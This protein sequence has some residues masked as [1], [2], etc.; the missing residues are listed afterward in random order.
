VWTLLASCLAYS[1]VLKMEAVRSYET[2][3]DFYQTERRCNQ[4]STILVCLLKPQVHQNICPRCDAVHL[5]IPE[6]RSHT[7]RD[8]C[9]FQE[10]NC[11][12]FSALE[13]YSNVS[14]TT[15]LTR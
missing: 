8:L 13:T 4:V 15:D 7:K 14:A 9:S 5:R 2:L 11:L 12:I 3:V 10:G 6:F 1:S